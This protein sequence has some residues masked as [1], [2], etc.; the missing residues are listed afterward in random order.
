MDVTLSID[1]RTLAR[2]RQ[3]ALRRGMSLEEMIQN[4]LE[5]LT[6]SEP[7]QDVAELERLWSEEEGDSGGQK[8]KREELPEGQAYEAAKQAALQRLE[9]AGRILELAGTG[10]WEGDLSEMRAQTGPVEG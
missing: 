2:A 8:W 1:D 7:V 5:T 3:L 9:R 10:L 6:A 4:Y